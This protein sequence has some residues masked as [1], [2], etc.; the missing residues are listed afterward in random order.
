MRVKGKAESGAVDFIF[1]C[2][3]KHLLMVALLGFQILMIGGH[4]SSVAD[5]LSIVPR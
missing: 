4:L 2:K 5:A 1:L 3:K